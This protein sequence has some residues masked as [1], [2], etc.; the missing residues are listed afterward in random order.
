MI[1]QLGSITSSAVA[2]ALDGLALR[3]QVIA[4]N[5]ANAGSID[6][7]V[8]KV[9]FESA[10]QAELSRA[11]GLDE[12]RQELK[13]GAFTSESPGTAVELDIEMLRLNDTVLRYQALVQGLGKYGSLARMAITGEVKG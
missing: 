2:A 3:Q 8:R 1:D 11:G 12:F 4:G 13:S 9:D 10:L 6:Y 7:S 5:I